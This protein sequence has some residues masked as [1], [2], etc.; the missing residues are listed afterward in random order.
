MII[1]E[2]IDNDPNGKRKDKF[3]KIRNI[4]NIIFM[5]LGVIGVA[6]Y[7]LSSHNYGTILILVGMAFKFVEC[8]LRLIKM[9]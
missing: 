2:N 4:L 1:H 6:V 5:L 7:F 3:L 8:S 9:K